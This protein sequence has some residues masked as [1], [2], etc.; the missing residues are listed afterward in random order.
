MFHLRT[1]CINVKT[2]VPNMIK[3]FYNK[4]QEKEMNSSVGFELCIQKNGF[5]VGC[6]LSYRAIHA[7]NKGLLTVVMG[8]TVYRCL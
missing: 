5:F 8:I 6:V 7:D 2:V 4:N 1:L 3:R